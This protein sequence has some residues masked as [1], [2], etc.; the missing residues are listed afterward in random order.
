MQKFLAK[1]IQQEASSGSISDEVIDIS[2]AA[3]GEGIDLTS[4]TAKSL[5]DSALENV[6][7][8]DKMSTMLKLQSLMQDCSSYLNELVKIESKRQVVDAR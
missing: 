2:A 7:L 4:C 6:S 1:S 8:A 3:N 5:I